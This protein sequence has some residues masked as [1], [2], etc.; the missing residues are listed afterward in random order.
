MTM[1]IFQEQAA[2]LWKGK[3]VPTN[4]TLYCSRQH[5]DCNTYS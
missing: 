1:A 4:P 3:Q 2:K 5:G